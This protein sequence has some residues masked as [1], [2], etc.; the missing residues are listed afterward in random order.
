MRREIGY[1]PPLLTQEAL[2]EISW[3]HQVT[4]AGLRQHLPNRIIEICNELKAKGKVQMPENMEK[5]VC[6]TNAILTDPP[7][8]WTAPGEADKTNGLEAIAET[9]DGG[10]KKKKKNKKKKKALADASPGGE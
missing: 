9:P 10:A 7:F 5:L 8:D 2:D 6:V 3:K 1:S 4:S